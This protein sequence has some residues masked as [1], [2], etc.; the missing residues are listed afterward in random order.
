MYFLISLITVQGAFCIEIMNTNNSNTKKSYMLRSWRSTLDRLVE[1]TGT[2]LDDV[3]EYIGLSGGS[4]A[5]VFYVDP[6]A[7]VEG[8]GADPSD[9]GRFERE[10]AAAL[11]EALDAPEPDCEVTHLSWKGV[12]TRMLDC[13]AG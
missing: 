7:M 9:A 12:C 8:G 2:S 4:D 1:E 10:L 13:I 11:C 5:P 3:C 6:P